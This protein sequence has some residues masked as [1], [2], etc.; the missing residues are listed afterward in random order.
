[1]RLFPPKKYKQPT[2]AWSL[3]LAVGPQALR[4]FDESLE[5]VKAESG[6]PR[7]DGK[8]RHFLGGEM[9]S[10]SWRFHGSYSTVDGWNTAFTSWYIVNIPLFI[11]FFCTS[12][13]VVWDFWTTNSI[14]VV[15]FWKI[16]FFLFRLCSIPF[17]PTIME[18]ETGPIVKE[19]DFHDCWRKSKQ[20]PL[21]NR[22]HH[23]KSSTRLI[24]CSPNT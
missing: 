17:L 4:V 10:P 18:V 9:S 1:M 12:Q 2:T 21:P 15:G 24:T 23:Q 6:K 19:T 14:T 13:V 20:L 8:M 16:M 22:P 5:E 3:D 7:S 11:G